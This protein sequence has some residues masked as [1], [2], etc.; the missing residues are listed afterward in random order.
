MR[1]CVCVCEARVRA[2]V[3]VCVR[4]ACVRSCVCEARVRAFVCVCVSVCEARV[5]TEEGGYGRWSKQT[6]QWIITWTYV[7]IGPWIIITSDLPHQRS[8]KKMHTTQG[9][10][11]STVA[12]NKIK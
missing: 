2:F 7:D 9:H 8:R 12:K 5:G 3:C 4:R 1:S 10:S 6:S 11:P